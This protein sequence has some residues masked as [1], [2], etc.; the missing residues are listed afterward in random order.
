V[1]LWAARAHRSDSELV[2]SA[3]LAVTLEAAEMPRPMTYQFTVS[4]LG[5][6]DAEDAIAEV[7]LDRYWLMMRRG[8]A[9]LDGTTFRL[10]DVAHEHF[11]YL[12]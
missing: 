1:T 12:R 9:A 8:P 10:A 4:L 6:R 3:A 2:V 11:G 7:M 5:A